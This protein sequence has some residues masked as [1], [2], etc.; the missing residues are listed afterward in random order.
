LGR[1]KLP[2]GTLMANP[3]LIEPANPLQALMMGQQ[4]YKTG[5]EF[6]TEAR[7]TNALSQLMGGQAGGTPDYAGVARSLAASGDLA[8]ATQI[9]GLNKALA[10]PEQTDEIKEYTLS[11]AQGYK[12][13]FTDW[14]TALKLAGATKVNTNVNTGEKEYDKV[15]G[16]AEAERFTGYQKD[17][18]GA[19]G[20][21]TTLDILER[22]ANDP[23][24]YSGL[25]AESFVLPIKQGI[26]AYGGDPSAAA[27][28]ETFRALSSKS[29]L[30][31]AGGSLGTAVSNAD[32]AIIKSTVP[33]LQNTKEGNQQ[34]IDIGRKVAQR[35]Q[36]VGKL[37]REYAARNGGRIDAGFDRVL[38]EF[39][40]KNPMFKNA[41]GSAAPKG[42]T[43]VD[44]LLDKY[45]PR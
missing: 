35:K 41:P 21:K 33:N 27:S 17:A 1:A 12:G 11:K 13:S 30:E 2:D 18:Q 6:A 10:G 34:L 32:A 42:S 15:L 4:G 36:E 3:F 31:A 23:K 38:Q 28:M 9:A 20:Q 45:A 43:K 37:A 39:A 8:G 14:K 40:D 26:A 24:F 22:A 19:A 7:R 25:G 44:T 5:K 16:K 29:L